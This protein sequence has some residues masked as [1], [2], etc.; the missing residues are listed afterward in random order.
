[1]TS[2]IAVKYFGNG[3]SDVAVAARNAVGNFMTIDG[4]RFR[5]IGVYSPISGS[6]FN[7]L[8]G[9]GTVV[10]PMSTYDNI[11]PG[12]ID[13]LVIYPHDPN[14]PDAA[15][16]A[17]LA[18][19]RHI[20]GP[21][22]QYTT[23]NGVQALGIFQSILSAVSVGLSAIGAVALVVAGIGIMN[24]M[25]VSVA[26]RKREIG[27]RKS[28]GASRND[29]V[30]QFLL[31]AVILASIGGGTGLILG[32]GATIGA[33]SYISQQLGTVIIPYLLLVCIAI[34]FSIGIGIAFGMYPA[35]RAA[36]LDPVEALRS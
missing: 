33:A 21:Q 5:A 24:I 3:S 2:D 28:I 15:I 12:P 27:I 30:L 18:A 26:E 20:H 9:S 23:Q 34:V 7:S 32:M 14:N 36:Q 22:A 25:L 17:T 1:M 8:A 10:L 11:A 31:E 29:I 19:L 16:A 6:L 35:L 4:Y 13:I